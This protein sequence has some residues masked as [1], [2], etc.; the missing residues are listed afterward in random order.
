MEGAERW[1]CDQTKI[2]V[3]GKYVIGVTRTLGDPGIK[4][5]RGVGQGRKPA[6]KNAKV[7]C[8]KRQLPAFH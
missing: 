3:L 8:V 2:Q 1:M 6:A 4:A 5:I 7:A